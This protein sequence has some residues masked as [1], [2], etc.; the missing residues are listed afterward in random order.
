MQTTTGARSPGT[1]QSPAGARA[2]PC[3][4]DVED[5]DIA[6][7]TG[8]PGKSDITREG[9]RAERGASVGTGPTGTAAASGGGADTAGATP[10][11]G[12]TTG[13][14]R[15]GEPPQDDAVERRE[16]DSAGGEG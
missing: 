16:A 2:D 12:G 8:I 14:P 5:I 11:P 9:T 3:S 4:T 6:V 1:E 10:P 15:M 7:G 13:G